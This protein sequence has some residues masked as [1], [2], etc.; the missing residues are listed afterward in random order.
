MTVN[1]GTLK[2]HSPKTASL[3]TILRNTSQS[4]NPFTSD[5]KSAADFAYLV[6]ASLVVQH[7]IADYIELANEHGDAYEAAGLLAGIDE[8]ISYA[9]QADALTV[10]DSESESE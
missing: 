10:S 4:D 3:V 5:P 6:S 2:G 7:A 8:A 1:P 9:V